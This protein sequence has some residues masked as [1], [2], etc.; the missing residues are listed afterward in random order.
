[1]S[2]VEGSIPVLGN[3]ILSAIK[4]FGVIALRTT[5]LALVP[6]LLLTSGIPATGDEVPEAVL[7]RH[8]E[9]Q[10]GIKELQKQS[11]SSLTESA[12]E[13]VA[14]I[15]NL[16]KE[17]Q[18]AGQ[19]EAVLALEEELKLLRSNSGRPGKKSPKET[20]KYKREFERRAAEIDKEFGDAVRQRHSEF[21]AVLLEAEKEET[22]A[23]R[24]D[25]ALAVREFRVEFEK[26]SLPALRPKDT[27]PGTAG[28]AGQWVDLLE[29]TEGFDWATRGPNWNGNLAEPAT[30]NGVVIRPMA[31]N[32][33][34][35]PAIIDGN[36]EIEVEWT[37][38]DG[39]EGVA[40][41]FPIGYRT[42]HLE[43]GI[44]TGQCAG[45]GYIDGTWCD[46]NE[47][48]RSPSHIAN[49]QK[50]TTVIR[51]TNDFENASIEIDHNE[52]KNYI[53]WKGRYD[54]LSSAMPTIR[55]PWVGAY[56]SR[57]V[58]SKIRVR[59]TS[60]E[61]R[62]DVLE[63]AQ[64]QR[65][66]RDGF[67]RLAYVAPTGKTVGWSEFMVNQVER[68]YWP[69]IQRDFTVCR[70][71]Y[72]AHA[73]SSLKIP[74]PKRMRSF[75]V[76]GYNDASRAARYL[77]KAD[78]TTLYESGETDIQP[79]KVDLP[80][81]AAVL[82][83]VVDPAGDNFRDYAYWC[84]PRFHSTKANDLT[85]PAI[86]GKSGEP[87]QRFTTASVGFG[88]LSR[89]KPCGPNISSVPLHYTDAVPCDEF[90]FAHAN[91]SVIFPVP[92]GMT[93][94]TAIGYCILSQSVQFKVLADTRL[95]YQSPQ[96]G[97]IPISVKLP[98]GTKQLELQV[99]SLGDNGD[100]W[101][102]WCYPRLHKR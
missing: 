32:K 39:V 67:V 51:V 10:R 35:L 16:R 65:D 100:D 56:E 2:L 26:Q 3:R 63:E 11:E 19:L 42:M 13:Y 50:Q 60:G 98:P 53:T 83:L 15:E 1:M 68:T 5:I 12:A 86:S 29:W 58:F 27:A 97:I 64:R 95:I 93:R 94:F 17:A 77:V 45:V 47:T 84:Y 85:E 49:N 101:S 75:S 102:L 91:S 37:R 72:G 59:M 88:E 90:C 52:T 70:D 4:F 78:G 44:R 71:F 89:N 36:Y 74:V 9:Y 92:E 43:F 41:W 18:S 38:T 28:A 96:A 54:R 34:P 25:S 46:G 99:D 76:V 31:W 55:H 30:K 81:G 73:P 21:K 6:L 23:D 66:L 20:A 80:E 57:V 79:I 14:A 82:E 22:R 48:T 8:D 69:L 7:E 24:I 40:I 62:R 33:F 87:V 61:I